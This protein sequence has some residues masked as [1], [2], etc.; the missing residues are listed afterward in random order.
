MN[1]YN[2]TEINLIDLFFYLLQHWRSLLLT[3]IVGTVL[4]LGIWAYRNY[5]LAQEANIYKTADEITEQLMVDESLIPDMEVAYQYRTLYDKQLTYNQNSLIMQLDPN[6]V[7]QGK[8]QYYIAAG[9]DTNIISEQFRNIINNDLAVEIADITGYEQELQYILETIE[10]SIDSKGSIKLDDEEI[11]YNSGSNQTL[12]TFTVNAGTA[13]I[14][15]SIIDLIEEKANDQLTQC[16]GIFGSFNAGL[17]DKQVIL[18]INTDYQTLQ[19][20]NT[21]A[22]NSYN[23]TFKTLEKNF[24]GDA[25]EYYQITY[26]QKDDLRM[27]QENIYDEKENL[28]KWLIIG[29]F[30]TGICWG[31]YFVIKY[32][33]DKNI[34]TVDDIK[35]RYNLP[36]IA[37]LENKQQLKGLDGIIANNRRKANGLADKASSV[38]EL[39]ENNTLICIEGNDESLEATYFM[40]KNPKINIFKINNLYQ[41]IDYIENNAIKEIIF[42]IK[43]N[44]TKLDEIEKDINICKLKQLTIKGF[45]VIA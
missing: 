2:E 13:E 33:L 17:I 39:I 29:I 14:C 6:N 36:I 43:L 1:D 11:I 8:L 34:K 3:I 26:L 35:S 22:L 24:T 42:M 15:T 41:N 12:V 28:V 4:G 38:K 25:L 16:Q 37:L 23:N 31:I 5:E 9:D 32:L 7:Y 20:S 40:I 19:K 27:I 10:C 18:T 44:E 21:D 45:I 30:V